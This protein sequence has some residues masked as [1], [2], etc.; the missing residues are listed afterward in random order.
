MTA[1]LPSVLRRGAA[2]LVLSAICAVAAA[3]QNPAVD[4]L[5][6]ARMALNDL[7]YTDA[8]S[9]ARFVLNVLGSRISGEQRVEALSIAAAARFPEPILGAEQYP[10]SALSALRQLIRI[11][12]D[13]RLRDEVRWPGLDSLFQ[14]ARTTTFAARLSRPRDVVLG[15]GDQAVIVDGMSTRRATWTA[16]LRPLAGGTPVY[17]TALEP[18][19]AP[20]LRLRIEL[21]GG[22]PS[23]PTGAYQLIVTVRDAA[24]A[25][26]MAWSYRAV[27]DAAPVELVPL[28]GPIDP[29]LFRREMAPP[30]RRRGIVLGVAL[31][32][33]SIAGVQALRGSGPLVDDG[34]ALSTTTAVGAALA[35]GAAASGFLDKGTPIPGNAAFNE[36][37]RSDHEVAR[38]LAE[39]ENAQRRA[40]FRATIEFQGIPQ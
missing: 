35:I 29:Q 12:P 2:A 28:P 6:R 10:D 34:A 30:A 7:R 32:A 24:S 14:V 1:R 23:I 18:T 4:V 16:E 25:D 5:L 21:E 8:D 13:T 33:I 3:A 40:A 27:V 36:R 39:S 11:D 37:L 26:S 22:R 38:R 9:L 31:G 19:Q 15:A 20:Q 17:R